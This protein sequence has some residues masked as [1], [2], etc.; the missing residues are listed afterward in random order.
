MEVVVQRNPIPESPGYT[1]S[2]YI[3]N[4]RSDIIVIMQI[5]YK[6]YFAIYDE[7]YERYYVQLLNSRDVFNISVSIPIKTILYNFEK[8]NFEEVR[9]G[10]TILESISPTLNYEILR[11]GLSSE[12]DTK[13]W[14]GNLVVNEISGPYQDNKLVDVI[15]LTKSV[16]YLA[17]PSDGNAHDSQVLSIKWEYQYNNEESVAFKNSKR[18]VVIENGVKKCKLEC[19]FHI[20][21]DIFEV[22][23]FAFYKTKSPNVSRKTLTGNKKNTDK[24]DLIW[25]SKLT[26]EEQNKIIEISNRLSSDPNHLIAAMALETGGTFNPALV[27]SLGYTGLIQIGSQAAKDINRRKGTNITAGKDGNLVKMSRLE[28]LKYVEYYLE[29]FKGKLNTLGDF[30]LAIL[31]PVDCGKGNLPNHVVFDKAIKLD[32]DSKG[33]V[34]KNTKWLRQ[35]AYAQNPAFHKEK[36]EQGKTYVWEIT[37][38]IEK[39]YKKGVSE[40]G[41]KANSGLES[42]EATDTEN[43]LDLEDSNEDIV[44]HIFQT[45]EIQFIINNV[46]RKTVKYIYYDNENQQHDLGSYT[47][48]KVKKYY[49]EPQYY[50]KLGKDTQY[51]YLVDIRNIKNYSS[52]TKKFQLKINTNRYYIADV[53]MASLF[54]AMLENS[55]LDY[56]FNGFSNEIGQSIGGSTSHK[57]GINGD[58]RYLRKDLSGERM[59][60]FIEDETG[61]PCGWKGLD[62]ERQNK[63][64]DALYK[65]GW[66]SM[67]SQYYGKTGSKKLLNHC[68]DDYKKKAHNDHLHLQGYKPV[69][70][71]IKK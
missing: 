33:N 63:F 35:R 71:E 52:E 12:T 41:S 11:L 65:F 29:P 21:E 30:Y 34:I 13:V 40:K 48:S 3:G 59:N 15:D 5:D 16:Y 58:L 20:R 68:S 61:D 25:S 42:Q 31:F 7:V 53:V 67:L 49:A 50:D 62:E 38:E 54:G 36:P 57:H 2:A 23:L 51:I 44:F 18:S 39:W 10:F 56:V 69:I 27:N 4:Y 14:T 46:R 43:N 32:Y 26:I 17:T 60:L 47:I 55:Y 19:R 9:V 8:Q 66:K 37:Q 64:N 28:Q 6:Y 45:G 70:K 1:V 24:S 22:T